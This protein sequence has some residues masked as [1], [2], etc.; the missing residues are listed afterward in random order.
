MFIIYEMIR[1][2]PL[3]LPCALIL[4]LCLQDPFRSYSEQILNRYNN[5]RKNPS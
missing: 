2:K 1:A 4:R 5:R 3:I